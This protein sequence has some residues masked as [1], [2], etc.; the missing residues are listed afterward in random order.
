M[1]VGAVDVTRVR[2]LLEQA[3]QGARSRAS[4]SSPADAFADLLAAAIERRDLT[5]WATGAGFVTAAP[6]PV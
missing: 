2:S 5:R 6:T 1:S 3:Q 4:S